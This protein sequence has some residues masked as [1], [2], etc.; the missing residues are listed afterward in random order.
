MREPG[1]AKNSTNFSRGKFQTGVS[2]KQTRR[3]RPR[4]VTLEIPLRE[5]ARSKREHTARGSG[6]RRRRRRRSQNRNRESQT[7]NPKRR[8]RDL[9]PPGGRA[10]PNHYL[11][12]RP[13]T[14]GGG[15]ADAKSGGLRLPGLAPVTAPSAA[16]RATAAQSGAR[17]RTKSSFKKRGGIQRADSLSASGIDRE[18]PRQRR[19]AGHAAADA[20]TTAKRVSAGPHRVS[21]ARTEA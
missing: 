20:Q 12:A 21:A 15:N 7:P 11:P 19:D 8:R 2:R 14:Q 5:G 3:R 9:A 1:G 10:T 17:H 6:R 16:R 4:P 18:Q 13:L